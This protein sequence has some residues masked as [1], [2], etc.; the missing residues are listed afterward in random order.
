MRTV[1]LLALFLLSSIARAGTPQP[2]FTDTLAAGGLN[3]P[4]ALAFMPDGRMLVTQK[5]GELHLV[6]GVNDTNLV[7]IP[8]CTDSEMGLLGIALD[9]AFGTNGFI[10]LYRTKPGAGGCA[11]SVGRFSQ[12]VRVTFGPGDTVSIGSLVTL[13]DGIRTD[14][15]NHDGGAIRLGSDNTLYVGVGDTGLGDNVGGPGSATNPY[16]QDLKS[17]NGK[18]LRINLDGTIPADNPFASTPGAVVCSTSGTGTA[19]CKE[20]WAYGFRNPFRMSFDGM[21]G[22]LWI[23]DVGD[24]TVEEV[25]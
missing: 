6:D 14:N 15:G 16:A 20:V 22:T 11:T 3:Q 8:V 5:G 7:T 9:P 18:I 12:V 2:G 19:T 25:Y 23:A 17:L 13:I 10:Y 4:T 21:T 1:T 24:L